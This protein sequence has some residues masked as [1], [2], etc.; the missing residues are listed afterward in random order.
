MNSLPTIQKQNLNVY[1][2][3]IRALDPELYLIKTALV[4]TGVNP[5]LLPPIIRAVANLAY[6]SKYGKVQIFME[7][8]VVS[9]IKP[10]E[11]NKV[12]EPALIDKD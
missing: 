8:G 10:E 11:S 3:V 1:W 2:E 12:Q 7:D 4:E 6:G 5:M 9:V